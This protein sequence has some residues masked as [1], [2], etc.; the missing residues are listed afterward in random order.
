[1]YFF[2][3]YQ[4]FPA[5]LTQV[6]A[7]W[8]RLMALGHCLKQCWLLISSDLWFSQ[9]SNFR[10]SQSVSLQWRH[11]GRDGIWNHQPHHCLL[12]RLFRRISKKTSKLQVTGFVW[13]I[14]RWPV[15]S[16]HK[17][18]VMRK[19]FPFD[20]VILC[21]RGLMSLSSPSQSCHVCRQLTNHCFPARVGTGYS[22]SNSYS[23]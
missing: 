7:C 18:P 23:P 1:M 19:M 10:A 17:W 6:L 22:Q 15:N 21:K 9:E 4:Y 12:N 11:D 3:I 13:G 8:L 20:D 2:L 5:I 14:H 16:P